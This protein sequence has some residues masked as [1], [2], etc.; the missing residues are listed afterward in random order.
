MNSE[1]EGV[2]AAS[3][4][5]RN[6]ELKARLDDL[7]AAQATA[8]RLGA[9]R[10]GILNQRDTYFAVP[11]GRLKLR[12]IEGQAAVLIRYDRPDSTSS[13]VSRYQLVPVDDPDSLKQLLQDALGVRAVVEKH[14]ELYL[15]KNVRIHLDS[16]R[17]LG[18][19]LEFEAVL[20]PEHTERAGRELLAELRDQFHIAADDLVATSYVDLLEN[21]LSSE[22]GDSASSVV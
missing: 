8:R 4:I 7:S 11:N 6:V 18:S 3:A 14:R 2:S 17:D 1:A 15:L 9:K 10:Q 22:P 12:E 20:G 13:R 16:V 5:R 19:F 21:K